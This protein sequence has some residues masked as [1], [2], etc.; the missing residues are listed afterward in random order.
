[1]D[2]LGILGREV[3]GGGGGGWREGERVGRLGGGG[4]DIGIATS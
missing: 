3:V 4:D 2:F 1:M